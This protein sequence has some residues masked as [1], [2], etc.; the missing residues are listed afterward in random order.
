[1]SLFYFS[2]C[3]QVILLFYFEMITLVNLYPWN[4]LSNYTKK[5]KWMEALI[6]GFVIFMSLCLYLTHIKILMFIAVV[7]YFVFFI[8]QLLVWWLPYLTGIHLKQFPKNLYDLHFRKTFKILPP[9][10]DNIIPDAQHNVLQLITMAT[11]LV[12]AISLFH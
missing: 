1:M 3:L 12:S 4:D 6:N 11:L 7:C 9:I 2:I 8:M 10:K 5:E